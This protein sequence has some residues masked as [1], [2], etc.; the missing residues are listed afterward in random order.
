MTTTQREILRLFMASAPVSRRDRTRD[1]FGLSFPLIVSAFGLDW[2]V[3][4]GMLV[5]WP[6]VSN[7]TRW[8]LIG[9]GAYPNTA[10]LVAMVGSLKFTFQMTVNFPSLTCWMASL[11]SWAVADFINSSASFGPL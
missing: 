8:P 9:A 5:A 10:P 3:V 7:T 1:Y 6:S 2:K 11:C 4:S